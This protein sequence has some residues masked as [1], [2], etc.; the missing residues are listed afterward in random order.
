[1]WSRKPRNFG[2]IA[3]YFQFEDKLRQFVG[4][5]AANRIIN[6]HHTQ[7]SGIF[8]AWISFNGTLKLIVDIF[9]AQIH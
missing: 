3:P 1:M 8:D 2:F 6:A 7:H 5:N 9:H 4:L